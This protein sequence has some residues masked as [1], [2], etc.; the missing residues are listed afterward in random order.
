MREGI[1]LKIY[2]KFQELLKIHSKPSYAVEHLEY[3]IFVLNKEKFDELSEDKQMEVRFMMKA[4]ELL[5]GK[6]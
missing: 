4:L 2:D 5:H 6:E 3:I 1:E